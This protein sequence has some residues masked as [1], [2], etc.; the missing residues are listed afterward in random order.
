MKWL[1]Y[2]YRESI[3]HQIIYGKPSA[4][5]RQTGHPFLG[6]RKLYDKT[7]QLRKGGR[8]QVIWEDIQLWKVAQKNLINRIVLQ[9]LKA[10]HSSSMGQIF[11]KQ[12]STLEVRV[13]G[14]CG[15]KVNRNV[16]SAH[17]ERSAAQTL[18]C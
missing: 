18:I 17:T 1:A 5:F 2:G 7:I 10:A 12:T 3:C 8:K 9:H 11:S 15:G 4:S 16:S 13:Q 14:A 6:R